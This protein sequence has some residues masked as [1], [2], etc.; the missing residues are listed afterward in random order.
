V[1]KVE[2]DEWER[3]DYVYYKPIVRVG[4]NGLASKPRHS[5]MRVPQNGYPTSM[6]RETAAIYIV[7]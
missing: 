6:G 2:E 5:E 4:A 7:E 3:I 1:T